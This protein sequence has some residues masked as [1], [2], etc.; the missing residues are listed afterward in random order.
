[1]YDTSYVTSLV[2][3]FNRLKNNRK[4]NYWR[5]S[6]WGG[7]KS[8]F[9]LKILYVYIYNKENISNVLQ[10]IYTTKSFIFTCK[11]ISATSR[12]SLHL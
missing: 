6:L 11:F 2:I 9:F 4:Y 3:I 10:D 1:M 12:E 8:L 7:E 5:K